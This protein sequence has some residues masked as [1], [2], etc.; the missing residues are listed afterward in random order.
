MEPTPFSVLLTRIQAADGES[1][2]DVPEDWLQGRT[3]F[4]GLQA[5][6]GLAA[7]RTVAP[8][9]PLRS[10][11]VTFLA[12]VPGGPVQARARVLRSGKNT[13][14]VEAR[15]V[16]GDNTLCLMVGVFGV[17]RASAVALRPQQPS[18]TPA[19]TFELPWV[20]GVTP[21]FTQ[22]FK[23]R[24]IVGAPPY[25]GN[26]S[27][28]SVIELGMRDDGPTTESHV[29]AMADFIPP[30][31]LSYLKTP[32]P[33]ASLTWM[34]ELLPEDFGSLALD[35]WRIDAQMTAAH[36]GYINQSLILWG[37]AGVPVAL[38]RQTMVVFG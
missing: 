16:D 13:T 25:T 12:P 18:F 38:G 23:A 9:A 35:G 31:A 30:I 17:A 21:N 1:T 6:V 33:A 32:V 14:H 24:W 27:P 4:G 20:P 28:E 3:L 5:V 11:Q 22:H 34:L 19:K 26:T 29:V 7:M 2:L 10:L 8:A 37:P 15:V 36:S